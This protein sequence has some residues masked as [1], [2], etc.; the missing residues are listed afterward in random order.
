MKI[1]RTVFRMDEAA[2]YADFLLVPLYI[3]VLMHENNL[4]LRWMSAF[5]G[6]GFLAWTLFEYLTHRY[7]LHSTTMFGDQHDDHHQHPKDLIGNPPWMTFAITA[8]TWISLWFLTTSDIAS[9]LTTG[10]LIG[11][12]VY[13]EIHMQL[14]H[15]NDVSSSPWPIPA[16]YRHHS[17][18]HRGGKTNFGVTTTLWD[19]VFR[20]KV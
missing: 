11:Y 2:Y 19:H 12:L 4:S 7:I 18:H 10:L 14:H 9:A 6:I 17:G 8:V 1:E 13:S 16:L 20:T 3:I 15:A 5:I